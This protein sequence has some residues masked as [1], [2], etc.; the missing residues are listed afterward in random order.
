MGGAA[1]R[2]GAAPGEEMGRLPWGRRRR[3]GEGEEYGGHK[4]KEREPS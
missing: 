2:G 4:G 3:M 1:P